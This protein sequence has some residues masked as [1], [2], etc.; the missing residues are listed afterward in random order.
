MTIGVLYLLAPCAGPALDIASVIQDAQGR[1]FNVCLGLSPT[2]AQW[3][4][5]HLAHLEQ[6]A[7]HPARSDYKMP[8]D[9]DVWPPAD[10]I[11]VAPATFNT[12][13]A[14]ALG[15]TRDFVVGVAAEATGRGVPVVRMPCVSTARVQR[16]QFERSI[17]ELRAMGVCVLYGDGEFVPNEPGQQGSYPWYL[18]LDG[19]QDLV[20]DLRDSDANVSQNERALIVLSSRWSDPLTRAMARD[21]YG[22]PDIGQVPQGEGLAARGVGP[23]AD[24]GEGAAARPTTELLGGEAEGVRG[25]DGGD[26]EPA[27]TSSG[28]GGHEARC[29][30][31]DR[32]WTDRA[33]QK[34]PSSA[35]TSSGSS[36]LTGPVHSRSLNNTAGFQF[37]SY[38][39]LSKP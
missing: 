2:A 31:N 39:A 13:N 9:P 23:R 28:Y 1:G 18:V 10:V 5:P 12:I 19:T 4:A 36:T 24:R 27:L 38:C 35:D 16:R 20:G 6:L 15:V 7:G 17:K 33:C 29:R 11:A 37:A 26:G 3:L 21:A 8:A 14:W 32:R 25:L 22:L 34:S 30:A